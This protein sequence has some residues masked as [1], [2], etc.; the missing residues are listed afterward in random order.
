MERFV[1]FA[2]FI[3]AVIIVIVGI[4]AIVRTIVGS[5][6]QEPDSQVETSTQ[7]ANEENGDTD[8]LRVTASSSTLQ[9]RGP[10]VGRED[11]YRVE[12]VVNSDT[13]KL[14]IRK[15][16]Q[17][18]PIVS[19][20]RK[21]DSQSYQ[22]FLGALAHNGINDG[23]KSETDPRGYCYRGEL[24]ELTYKEPSREITKWD[25]SCDNRGDLDNDRAVVRLFTRQF[26]DIDI[27]DELE[28]AGLD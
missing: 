18:S 21:N 13:R 20:L 26:Q 1:R 25:S 22:E 11:S 8:P 15:G 9:I 2:L 3:V 16:D 19:E 14:T 24:F 28:A 12:I 27:D 6:S 4:F 10:I 23:I 5:G 17:S 7:E